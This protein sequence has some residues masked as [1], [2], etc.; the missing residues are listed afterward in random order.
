LTPLFT[1]AIL[2]H[3]KGDKEMFEKMI[4]QGNEIRDLFTKHEIID[5][6]K[7]SH[8]FLIH[9]FGEDHT[10]VKEIEDQLRRVR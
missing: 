8:E 10:E 5:Q 3:R 2:N 4:E 7:D 1:Y 6:L 9:K